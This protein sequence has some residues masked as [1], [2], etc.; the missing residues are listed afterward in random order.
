MVTLAHPNVRVDGGERNL[1]PA[2][3]NRMGGTPFEMSV[4][5]KTFIHKRT[6]PHLTYPGIA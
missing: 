5:G 6:F 4:H 3:F 2:L 1:S